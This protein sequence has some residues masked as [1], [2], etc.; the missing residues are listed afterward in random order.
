MLTPTVGFAYATIVGERCVLVGLLHVC[1]VQYHQNERSQEKR[2]WL[3][4]FLALCLQYENMCHL[5]VGESRAL[6]SIDTR[7]VGNLW[8]FGLPVIVTTFG[9]WMGE[10]VVSSEMIDINHEYWR[11]NWESPVTYTLMNGRVV[12]ILERLRLEKTYSLEELGTLRG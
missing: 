5:G 11:R 4:R 9:F 6:V 7:S 3:H 12:E 10:S 1:H 2:T 8:C